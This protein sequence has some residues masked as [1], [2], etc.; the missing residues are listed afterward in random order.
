MMS[1]GLESRLGC[2]EGK[3]GYTYLRSK[4]KNE[5]SFEL[6]VNGGHGGVE[7]ARVPLNLIFLC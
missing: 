7:S 3:D 4:V 2:H 6:F 5:D 1:A